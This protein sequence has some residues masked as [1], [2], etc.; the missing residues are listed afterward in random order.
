MRL[1]R[2]L[3]ALGCLGVLTACPK[4]P[5]TVVINGQEVPYE[6]AAKDA[7]S[8]AEDSYNKKDFKNAIER[9]EAFMRD[10]PKSSLVADALF[11]VGNSHEQ[12]GEIP[13]A[14]RAFQKLISDFP[15]SDLAGEA[16]LRLGVAYIHAERWA[17]A[18]EILKAY[19]K[20]AHEPKK[21]GNARLLIA[22]SLEKQGKI[23][24]TAPWRLRAAKDLEDPV[25]AAWSRDK[26]VA[27]LEKV[28]D[29]ALI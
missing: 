29:P 14:G 20:R 23:A 24:E 15:S 22:E 9:Y 18:A 4:P 3:L 5:K 21:M 16:R 6:V 2:L 13:D 17:D 28:S 8:K 26:G 25:L 1:R 27:A 19:E 12:L 10:F 11:R 7:F